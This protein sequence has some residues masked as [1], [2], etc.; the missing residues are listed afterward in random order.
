MVCPRCVRC[1]LRLNPLIEESSIR[2]H[3]R[4]ARPQRS[5]RVSIPSSRNRPFGPSLP[6]AASPGRYVSIPSSRNRPFGPMSRATWRPPA[7]ERLNPLIEESSIR[8][9]MQPVNAVGS[10]MSQS[11]HRGIV[12]SDLALGRR[13]LWIPVVSI[14]SSRNRPFGL[15]MARDL[16]INVLL[17]Q[18]PHRGIVHSDRHVPAPR[19]R[20]RVRL[21]PLIEESSI[22]TTG[23]GTGAR[24]R[25]ASQSPH[26][27]IVHSDIRIA[28][29]RQAESR[30]VSIPSSRNRPFGQAIESSPATAGAMRLNPLIEESSIRTLRPSATSA[31]RLW[32]QSPH[33]GIVHSDTVVSPSDMA[34]AWRCL[35]PLIEESSIRT[36]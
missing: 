32:S 10:A 35:N 8:T 23:P 9:L 28:W 29:R 5:P 21:N 1:L 6:A 12:H 27:G 33:R 4:C 31:T 16:R 14:P 7:E 3:A 18:S 2:T 26:R 24:R 25:S 22:R 15:N 17:S 13:L 11:P 20:G 19:L 30:E 36:Q 34:P